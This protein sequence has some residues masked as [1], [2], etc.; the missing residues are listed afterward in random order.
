[1]RDI[2]GIAAR[3][4]LAILLA[5]AAWIGQASPVAAIEIV[6]KDGRVL[7]GKEGKVASLADRL[8][9]SAPDSGAPLQLIVFL[10]DNLRRTYFSDRLVREV[11]QEENRKLDEKFSLPQRVRRSGSTV[12]GVGQPAGVQP[13]DEFGRR[14]FTINTAQ[15]QTDVVQGI[16]ELTPQWTKVEGISHV[17]DMRIATSSIPRDILHKI[18]LKRINPQSVE[19]YKKVA[20]FYLQCQRYADARA[21]LDD[22]LAKFPHQAD[23]KEQLAPSLRAIAQ[24]SAEQLLQEL[25]FRRHAG[26]H[27]L[28]CDALKRFPA[29]GV[30][31]EILQGVRDMSQDYETREARRLD[32]IKHLK[33]LAAK[34]PDTI[35]RENLKP[36]LDEIAADIGPNT[37][38]RMASFL[39]SADDP[40][41]GDAENLALAI[42]GWLLRRR[43]RHD[44]AAQGDFRL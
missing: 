13:F 10:D 8:Q 1:M 12:R 19:D 7:R 35:A 44:G 29:A 25:E 14:T 39:Q 42:S 26:Q 18:L 4:W 16:T 17:W 30:G 43:C 27:R 36:I 11:R 37:L 31:G 28:V 33:A 23:L 24:L 20:R 22:L 38:D 15:G 5:V 6:L 41:S 40:Q 21:V 32:V 2:G 3:V 34:I 9:A